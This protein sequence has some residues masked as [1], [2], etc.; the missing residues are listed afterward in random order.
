MKKLHTALLL[1]IVILLASCEGNTDYETIVTNNT[2]KNITIRFYDGAQFLLPSDAV[3]VNAGATQTIYVYNQR[4]GVKDAHN[5][6]AT[7]DSVNTKIDGAALKKDIKNNSNWQSN[8]QRRSRVPADYK[9]TYTF[10][11]NPTDLQ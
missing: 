11:I 9:H 8:V 2:S 6:V 10:V 7:L 1:P 5:P 4:G 3:T